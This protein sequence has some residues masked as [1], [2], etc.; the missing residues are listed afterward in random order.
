MPAKNP[1]TQPAVAVKKVV[2]QL[3]KKELIIDIEDAK[4][5]QKVLNELFGQV[6]TEKVVEHHHH[7]YPYYWNYPAIQWTTGSGNGYKYTQNDNT[8]Y[9]S[10][11][12]VSANEAAL[13]LTKLEIK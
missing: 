7:S 12:G 11:G 5:L 4:E 3:G 10:F 13:G 1:E 6:V 8:V 2:V 9:C